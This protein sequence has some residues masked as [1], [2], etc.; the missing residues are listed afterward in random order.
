LKKKLIQNLTDKSQGLP[1]DLTQVVFHQFQLTTPMSLAEASADSAALLRGRE[2]SPRNVPARPEKLHTDQE[3]F[4][5]AY[6]YIRQ[7][8]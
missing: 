2:Q 1:D 7:Y 8:Y 6:G 3:L 5:K 4:D